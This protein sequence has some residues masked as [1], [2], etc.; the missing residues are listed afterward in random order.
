MP[1]TGMCED[2]IHAGKTPVK[3][4]QPTRGFIER[5]EVIQRVASIADKIFRIVVK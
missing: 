5:S 1:H 3:A 2:C 4:P